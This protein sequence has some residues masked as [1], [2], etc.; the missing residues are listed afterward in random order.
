MTLVKPSE[1]GP[2]P[3]DTHISCPLPSGAPVRTFDIQINAH[4]HGEADGVRGELYVSNPSMFSARKIDPYV[5]I[6]VACSSS[7]ELTSDCETHTSDWLHLT[8]AK[9]DWPEEE[10]TESHPYLVGARC[11]TSNGL[12]V[13]SS[14]ADIESEFHD[15]TDES[16]DAGASDHDAEESMCDLTTLS[17][18]T[19]ATSSP[20]ESESEPEA[21]APPPVETVDAE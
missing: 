19:P 12:P 14:E 2:Q 5:R 6:Q 15:P 17:L 4:A 1:R 13:V 20:G 16:P 21:A 7:P 18:P 11:A 3:R 8:T 9:A 10:C